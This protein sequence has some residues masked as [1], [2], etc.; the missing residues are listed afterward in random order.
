MPPASK[1][2]QRLWY[3]TASVGVAGVTSATSSAVGASGVVHGEEGGI[4]G[5]RAGQHGAGAAR[6]VA[7]LRSASTARSSPAASAGCLGG[8]RHE[9]SPRPLVVLSCSKLGASPG[10]K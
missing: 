8:R 7:V 1:W 3:G 9:P 2:R 6:T 10:V 4:A 5:A